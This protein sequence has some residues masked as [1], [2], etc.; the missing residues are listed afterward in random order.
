[1]EGVE[2]LLM[3]HRIQA[4]SLDL[5]VIVESCGDLVQGVSQAGLVAEPSDNGDG[6]VLRKVFD[7]QPV[8]DVTNR[9]MRL[10][11]GVISSN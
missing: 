10:R 9:F 11:V 4:K 8:T 7:S 3:T 2:R 1:M 6:T 5:T